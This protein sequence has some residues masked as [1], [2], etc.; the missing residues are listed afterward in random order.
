MN[1]KLIAK[2]T[3]CNDS[4]VQKLN[5]DATPEALIQYTARVSN[6]QNQTSNNSK[7][8]AY[9]AKH[10]HWSI[11]EQADFTFEIT[12]SRAI[13]AQILR[14]KSFFFQ[15][16][17]MRYT[18]AQGFE[19]YDARRQDLSNKQNS[20][21]D[22]PEDTK[23]WFIEAQRAINAICEGF[24]NDA[25]AKGIAKE[26]SRFLLP[27]STQTVLYMK[28]SVRSWIHYIEVRSGPD[29]QLEHRE[30]ALAIKNILIK[31]IPVIA[32]AMNWIKS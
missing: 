6:P 2:T 24:Y 14:H 16:F 4:I 23:E 13:A 19:L 9:C 27:L 1:V 25:L 21:D 28:G 22:L 26:S 17:S 11:F 20:I 18:K 3:I 7:L 31:E 29:T 8:L 32:E 12:T 5:G 10:K 30:I 15:E